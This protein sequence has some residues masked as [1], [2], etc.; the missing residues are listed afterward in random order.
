[1][2]LRG[3]GRWRRPVLA[4][5][6]LLAATALTLGLAEGLLSLLDL[7]SAVRGHF[8]PGIYR[9]EPALG[10]AL[11][12]SYSGVRLDNNRSVPTTT[13]ALGFRGPE[14]NE[15]RRAAELRVLVLGNSCT[16][17]MGVA[18]DETYPAQLERALRE[19]G[20]EAAVF[21]AGVPGYDTS[22]EADLLDR[23]SKSVQPHVVAVT[24]LPND[25][26]R[27]SRWNNRPIQI[28]DG[29]LVEDRDRYLDWRRRIDQKGIYRS[30][31]Y[32]FV[33]VR[34]RLMKDR[35]G[36]RRRTWLG[37]VD[38]ERFQVTTAA[39]TRI[40]KASSTLGAGVVLVLI[41]R[42]EQA[43]GSAGVSDL[44]TV[45]EFGRSK[46]MRVVDPLETWLSEHTDVQRYFLADNVHLT[47]LG[48]RELAE[49][50][51]EAVVDV[52]GH[53]RGDNHG[54]DRR[55]SEAGG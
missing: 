28:I 27:S 14:W 48:Y 36:G 47:A 40:N 41:P 49:V 25:L 50:T 15:A 19:R 46:G 4:G 8:K 43:E 39:L 35:L 6:T 54:E 29:Y 42:R 22:Q 23:L 20:R 51:A 11:R 7:T 17:G 33:Y 21:N 9:T 2:S 30:A 52:V 37:E 1:M 26:V 38:P 31:L 44:Q 12:P 32:R 53:T 45:A 55:K 10:W 18:D 3:P 16:F 13:N 24:W 34:T 5:V